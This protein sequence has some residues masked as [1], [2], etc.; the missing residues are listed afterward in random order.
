MEEELI[1]VLMCV[2]N[3]PMDFIRKSVKSITTQTYQNLE[4]IIIIDN[5]DR[6]DVISFLNNIKDQRIHYYVNESNLGFVNSLNRGIKLCNG[7]YIARMDADDI[8]ICDRIEKQYI[9]MKKNNVD[10]LGSR[11]T[12]IDENGDAKGTSYLPVSDKYIRR[13][14]GYGRGLPHPTWFVKQSV[15]HKLHGYRNVLYIEDYDL[16]VRAVILGFRF[17]CMQDT[18]LYY[19]KNLQGIS[20]NNKGQQAVIKAILKQQYKRNEIFSV[21]KINAF[22]EKKQKEIQKTANYYLVTRKIRNALERKIFA[23]IK[24]KDILHVLFSKRLYI[25]FYNNICVKAVCYFDGMLCK[26][27]LKS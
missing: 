14:I 1:S 5:P 11:V 24:I 17:G 12:N 22:V 8:A 2:Y 13:F 20:Q 10:I 27:Y 23:E 19:R 16:L 25:D 26:R 21:E 18:N 7:N 9:Y 4:Y 6:K 3:E 15:Y